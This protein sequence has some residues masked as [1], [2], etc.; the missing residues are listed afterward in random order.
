MTIRFTDA[1]RQQMESLGISVARVFEQIEI[2]RRS[3]FLVRL[4][5]PCT[6]G[7][8]VRKIDD[9]HAHRYIALHASA[10]G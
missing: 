4:K 10:A 5:R 1:D 8:G 9:T 7:D 6:V 3:D 2:F